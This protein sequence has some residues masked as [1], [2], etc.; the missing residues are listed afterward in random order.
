MGLK[1]KNSEEA[2]AA[3]YQI[4]L[5]DLAEKNGTRLFLLFA[6]SFLFGF[7]VALVLAGFFK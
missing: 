6:G 7:V 1:K 5:Y 2:I 3:A 4:G